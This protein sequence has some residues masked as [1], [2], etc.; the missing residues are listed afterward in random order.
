[1]TIINNL[2]TEYEVVRGK[3]EI[4]IVGLDSNN[5][6]HHIVV[7]NY[8]S[9]FFIERD[10]FYK[11]V[12][13]I[14]H[15][16]TR[17]VD[18]DY[19]PHKNRK[20][21]VVDVYTRLPEDVPKIREIIDEDKA[22]HYEGDVLYPLRFIIDKGIY[23]SLE[24][25]DE[26]VYKMEGLDY[27][28]EKYIKPNDT[29][30]P[31]F[32]FLDMDMEVEF[33]NNIAPS[34]VN[35][36]NKIMAI[37]FM[38]PQKM[39]INQFAVPPNR[40]TTKKTT[41]SEITPEEVL[42]IGKL[43]RVLIEYPDEISMLK[44]VVKF[45]GD[46]KPNILT[47]YNGDE[48]DF[49]YLFNRLRRLGIPFYSLSRMN[50]A[51]ITKE[52]KP[53]IKGLVFFDSLDGYKKMTLGSEDSYSLN[54]VSLSLFNMG[55]IGYDEEKNLMSLYLHNY[56]K[57]LLYNCYDVILEYAL[58]KKKNLLWFFYMVKSTSGS[59]FNDVLWN[60]RTVDCLFLKKAKQRREVLPTKKRRDDEQERYE[61]VK[62]AVVFQPPDIG[63]FTEVCAIDLS[64]SYP[65]SA[66]TINLGADKYVF[67]AFDDRKL[68]ENVPKDFEMKDKIGPIFLEREKIVV[69]ITKEFK[70]IIADVFEEYMTIRDELK[71]RYKKTND[72]QDFILQ[73]VFKFI[74]NSIY[75]VLLFP[76]FRLFDKVEGALITKSG[77]T[78]V[79]LA[80]DTIITI[81]LLKLIYGD[82]D[83]IY[84]KS[85]FKLIVD[86]VKHVN[87]VIT[88]V[89][90]KIEEYYKTKLNCDI[91]AIKFD[92][93]KIFGS[94]FFKYVK[95]TTETAKK[96]Y[97]G[98]VI[99]SKGKNMDE[100]II[101]GYGRSDVSDLASEV[102]E[103]LFRKILYDYTIDG[104]K[105]K[106]EIVALLRD[107]VKAFREN[108]LPLHY[109]CQ[110]KGIRKNLDDYANQDWIRGARWFNENA[111]KLNTPTRYGHGS[112]PKFMYV[113]EELIP[114]GYTKSDIVALDEY[115]ELPKEIIDAMDIDK[116][117]EKTFVIKVEDIVSIIGIKETD[118]ATLT[119]IRTGT[120]V[121]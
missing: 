27:I 52:F 109:I 82:T 60:S 86:I 83:S 14:R 66:K 34:H 119:R 104:K 106:E 4:H 58:I 103:T 71:K 76:F 37:S 91:C 1:M 107:K 21:K 93:D 112:K 87:E 44:D 118:Y 77:R 48:F 29:F 116:M 97:A 31:N 15:L 95:G 114:V 43:K 80:K 67:P 56:D 30:L 115:N 25:D 70:G 16:I 13:K 96:M 100:L 92:L 98:R 26:K 28:D 11:N 81:L 35:P 94:I 62:G 9:H 20:A 32:Y 38:D 12:E 108:K 23:K 7:Y 6:E 99:Y 50:Y 120:I 102:R 24:Y 10:Y 46:L 40:I 73:E 55:K 111:F 36:F 3:P 88:F 110:S 2:V 89:N 53:V 68:L 113:K 22:L 65:S 57:F 117:I 39:R 19:I 69:F 105:V 79:L 49:P 54:N 78:S 45:I 18:V 85:P 90:K 8:E 72:P 121:Y 63:V 42:N 17:H 64:Q 33:K 74:V 47:A 75:G 101:K 61:K 84:F 51:I 41:V 59:S 5:K